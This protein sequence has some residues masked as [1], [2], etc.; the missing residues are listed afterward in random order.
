MITYTARRR[1]AALVSALAL[2]LGISACGAGEDGAGAD[3]HGEHGS[4]STS[5]DRAAADVTFA[6]QMIPHHRQ[7]LEMASLAPTRAGAEVTALAARISAAQDPEIATMTAW[8]EKWD[9]PVPSEEGDDHAGH[10]DAE[11]MMSPEDLTRLAALQGAAFDE[12]FLRQMIA[13]HEGAI[14][15]AEDVLST[16]SDPKVAALAQ[17]IS[18]TQR[19]EV[20]EMQDLLDR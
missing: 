3:G 1:A 9:E 4:S 8:L 20:D 13:H 14:T 16:G 6:Q 5:A 15:M 17:Q 19:A 2:G 10:G 12:E 18:D 7:A 11:G